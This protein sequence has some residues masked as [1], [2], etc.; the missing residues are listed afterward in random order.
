MSRRN[1]S[2]APVRQAW[3]V[4][5][6][7]PALPAVPAYLRVKRSTRPAESTR[8][9]LPVKNGWQFAQISRCRSSFFVDRVVQVAPHAQRTL[10][11]L[12]SGWIPV[13]MTLLPLD[14]AN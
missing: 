14:I 13:F 7:L 1:E 9:C 10:L 12:Y 3:A 6:F 5:F 8:R 2:G 4:V 11:T